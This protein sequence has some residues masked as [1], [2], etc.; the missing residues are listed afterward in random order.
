MTLAKSSIRSVGR[1]AIRKAILLVVVGFCVS[2]FGCQDVG[3]TWS[4]EARSPDGNWLATARSQQWGG[5]GTAYDTTTVYLKWVKGSQ[6]PKE[7]LEF[8]HQYATMSLKM[9]WV[10]PTHLEVTYG[11][12]AKP[13]DHVSL[14]FQVVKISGIDISVRDLS[15]EINN[16]LTSAVSQQARTA[17][18]NDAC[19]LPQGLQHEIA[20]KYPGAKL[21]SMSDLDENDRALFQK[22]HGNS[23]PGLVKVDFYGDGKPTLAL[24]LIARD[25]SKE[26]AELVVAHQVGEHWSLTLLDTAQSSV[27]VVWSQDPGEFHDVYGKKKIRATRPVIVFCGYNSWAILYAWTGKD[28][29]KIWIAD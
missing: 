25:K 22:D 20:N 19:D 8:S 10:T 5:P 12:S 21:V 15:K 2:E 6:A 18:P 11:P 1:F 14:D 7:V 27:P 24:V 29:K 17:P 3:T 4:E 9:E 28:A 23:C 26:K 13:A 16:R